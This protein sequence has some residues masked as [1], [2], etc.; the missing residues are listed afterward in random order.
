[1]QG[2]IE[3]MEDGNQAAFIRFSEKV[4][5]KVGQEITVNPAKKTR[6]L[7]Q[8]ATYWLYL[9]WCI[10]PFGGD[11]Q[12][13]GHFSIDALHE[14][15]KAWLKATH[16]QDFKIDKQ[17][18]TTTLTRQEFGRFFD[19]VNN[20]LMV[21]ILGVDTS[22]FWKDLEKFGKWQEFNPGDMRDFL[23]E[24]VPEVPF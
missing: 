16:P 10:D 17:F 21:E 11:L 18:T 6:S 5:F 2:K 15:V 8:N 9:T 3:V 19:I 14:D 24:R 23:K 7:K 22:P 4:N 13:S 20:E 12:S 1:M